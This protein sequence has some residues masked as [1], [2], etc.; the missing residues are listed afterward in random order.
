MERPDKG[1]HNTIP[2]GLRIDDGKLDTKNRHISRQTGTVNEGPNR[3]ESA[4]VTVYKNVHGKDIHV[5]N[6]Y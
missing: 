2:D 5:R 3:I 6:R 1:K 4:D